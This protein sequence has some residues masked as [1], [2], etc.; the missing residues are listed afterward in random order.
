M[1]RTLSG[2]Q[3]SSERTCRQLADLE[4]RDYH[5]RIKRLRRCNPDRYLVSHEDV[6]ELSA[7]QEAAWQAIERVC[8]IQ[9]DERRRLADDLHDSVGQSL[10]AVGLGLARLRMMTPQT[11]SVSAL[12]GDLSHELQEAQAIRN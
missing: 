2:H 12:M 3:Q 7:A 10:V 9:D 5:V 11:Q 1:S 8:D 4:R 6:T